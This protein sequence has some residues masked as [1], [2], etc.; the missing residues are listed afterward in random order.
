[1]SSVKKFEMIFV[2]QKTGIK[3]SLKNTL[4]SGDVFKE[5]ADIL[6]VCLYVCL[7]LCDFCIISS[8]SLAFILNLRRK[9]S[10]ARIEH[11]KKVDDLL[12]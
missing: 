4:S 2:Y 6:F 7:S 12:N 3:F 10:E 9:L 1:M 11:R 8:A 5:S